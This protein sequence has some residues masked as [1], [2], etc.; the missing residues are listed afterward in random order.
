LF[1]NARSERKTNFSK[2]KAKQKQNEKRIKFKLK[3]Y[4]KSLAIDFADVFVS[5]GFFAEMPATLPQ[6]KLQMSDEPKRLRTAYTSMQLMELEKEFGINKYLC[7]PRRIDL[8]TRLQLTERQIK[9]W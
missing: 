5:L 2:E 7:R 6:L 3:N 9:I 1:S 4:G 8:A